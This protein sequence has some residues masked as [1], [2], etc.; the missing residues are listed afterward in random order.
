MPNYTNNANDYLEALEV[1]MTLGVLD[2]LTMEQSQSLAK[3][4]SI[5]RWFNSPKV[6]SEFSGYTKVA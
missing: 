2:V 3:A 1:T 5:V 6:V 4:E